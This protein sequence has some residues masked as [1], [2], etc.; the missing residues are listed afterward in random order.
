GKSG[1]V[2]RPCAW[3]TAVSRF[4]TSPALGLS[5][6]RPVS[7]NSRLAVLDP[8]HAYFTTTVQLRRGDAVQCCT[9]MQMIRR[10]ALVV[11]VPLLFMLSCARR[12]PEARVESSYVDVKLCAGCHASR[13]ETYRKTGMVRSFYRATPDAM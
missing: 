9:T 10:A 13:W 6:R 11:L 12:Q 8:W 2:S 7:P 1:L 4:P 5:C 3:S